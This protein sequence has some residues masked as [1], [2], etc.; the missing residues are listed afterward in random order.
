MKANL[1]LS[2]PMSGMLSEVSTIKSK[3]CITWL[4]ISTPLFI[5]KIFSDE[6]KLLTYIQ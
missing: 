1:L 4:S 2:M 5:L 3:Y 6:Q